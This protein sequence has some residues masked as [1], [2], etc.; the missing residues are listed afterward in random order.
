MHRFG[1]LARGADALEGGSQGSGAWR[2][3][4]ALSIAAVADG[5]LLVFDLATGEVT[6]LAQD[7]RYLGRTGLPL[8]FPYVN[9][10]V[11]SPR[12]LLVSGYTSTAGQRRL[13]GVHRFRR[14]AAG[15]AYAGSFGPLPTVR[16][17]L[18]WRYWGAGDITRGRNGDLIYALNLP[19]VIYRYDSAGRQKA[20]VRA[21]V[22]VRG[23]PDDA[24]KIERQGRATSI[25]DAETPPDRLA[26]AVETANGLVLVARVTPRRRYWDL[27]TPAGAYVASR[28]VPREW[29]TA[30]GFDAARNLLW[31]VATHDDTP[32][33]VRLQIASGAPAPTTPARRSR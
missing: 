10:I 11:A 4:D 2:V 7:G 28:E 1:V 25:S 18:V 27:F 13:H 30:I 32:V 33:L 15:L 16:D 9:D 5:T 24:F 19:Y 29:G 3:P 17:T 22:R 31:T 12:E 8:R 26:M 20:V 21:P 23:T 14:S 6:T